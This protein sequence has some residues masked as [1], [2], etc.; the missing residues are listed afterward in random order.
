[1]RRPSYSFLNHFEHNMRRVTIFNYCGLEN[2]HEPHCDD[3]EHYAER[4]KIAIADPV[5]QASHCTLT[6]SN[7]TGVRHPFS[8]RVK[9]GRP[10]PA[11]ERRPE[12][13]PR[14][15]DDPICQGSNCTLTKSNHTG[16]RHPFFEVCRERKHS[17]RTWVAAKC[18]HA[19]GTKLGRANTAAYVEVCV[20]CDLVVD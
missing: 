15:T 4:K 6:K 14:I 16:V 1:M 13:C 9:V 12:K 20:D 2:C 19:N 7:H 11:A 10:C 18:N 3:L 17:N 8:D 5:C